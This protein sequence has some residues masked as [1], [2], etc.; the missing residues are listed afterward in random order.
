MR[1][2]LASA[3]ALLIIIPAYVLAANAEESGNNEEA[4]LRSIFS[5]FVEQI[6]TNMSKSDV[7]LKKKGEINIEK[8]NGYYAVTLPEMLIIDPDKSITKIGMIAINASPSEQSNEWK[9]AIALPMPIITKNKEGKKINQIEVSKQKFVGVYNPIIESFSK[10]G[11][12]YDDVKFSDLEHNATVD[13]GNISVVSDLEINQD[14]FSGPTNMVVKNISFTDNDST[15]N[16]TINEANISVEYDGLDILSLAQGNYEIDMNKIGGMKMNAK[17]KDIE[18][19]FKLSEMEFGFE[20]KKPQNGYNDNALK[21]KYEGLEPSDTKDPMVAF[22][23]R[24]MDFDIEF[25]KLPIGDLI[26]LGLMKAGSNDSPAAAMNVLQSITSLPVKMSK[27]GS[28]IEIE[29]LDFDNNMYQIKTRGKLNASDQSPLMVEGGIVM[30]A[31]GLKE[32]KNALNNIMPNASKQQQKG[33]QNVLKRISFIETNCG[34]PES[35]EDNYKC[36][37][38]FSKDGQIKLNGKPMT[39]MEAVQAVR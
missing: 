17:I 16:M 21:V 33:I 3:L 4:E 39:P 25:N 32:T 31:D 10:L 13:V 7:V 20:G 23:P 15:K 36:A 38:E 5:G 26:A 14:T 18:A 8:A 28:N 30:N 34:N 27:V 6:E 35:T 2:F 1:L 29:N 11:I 24:S 19:G 9:M 37:L 12:S 22:A